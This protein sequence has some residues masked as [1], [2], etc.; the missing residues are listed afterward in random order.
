MLLIDITDPIGRDVD[1][2]DL[3]LELRSHFNPVLVQWLLD[4]AHVIALDLLFDPRY[5]GLTV[6]YF[7]VVILSYAEGLH[8]LDRRVQELCALVVKAGIVVDDRELLHFLQHVM[9]AVQYHFLAVENLVEE[10]VAN[11]GSAFHDKDGLEDLVVLVLYHVFALNVKSRLQLVNEVYEE[12]PHCL[13]NQVVTTG[14]SYAF[15]AEI[16]A[17]V[18]VWEEIP[19]IHL[20]KIRKEIIKVNL[21]ANIL[22]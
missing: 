18:I 16:Y 4:I 22:R 10:P 3:S 19:Y 13:V 7:K 6:H 17:A 14:F 15:S 20:Q 9:I 1:I 12:V 11:G 5:V 21:I 2:V 8:L